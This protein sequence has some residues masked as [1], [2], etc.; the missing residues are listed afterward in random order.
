MIE[1]FTNYPYYLQ[2][3]PRLHRVLTL[4]PARRRPSPTAAETAAAFVE[5]PAPQERNAEG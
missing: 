3:A 1:I 4:T 5:E 2:N